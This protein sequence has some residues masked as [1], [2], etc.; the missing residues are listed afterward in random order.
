MPVPNRS[1]LPSQGYPEW[2]R[3]RRDEIVARVKSVFREPDYEYL[4]ELGGSGGE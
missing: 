3:Q 2:A 4:M 1:D